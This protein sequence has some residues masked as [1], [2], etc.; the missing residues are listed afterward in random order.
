[1]LL[2]VVLLSLAACGPGGDEVD[3]YFPT[4]SGLRWTY[5]LTR[6][7]MDG[8]QVRP[9]YVEHRG[10]VLVAGRADSVLEQRTF[11]GNRYFF[12]RDPT[13]GWLRL[14]AQSATDEAPRW[15]VEPWLVLPASLDVG[16]SWQQ[17]TPV[18][19]LE[20]T[21]PPQETLFRVQV[22]LPVE[23]R[24]AARD[25][26]VEVPAGSF[27]GCLRIEGRGSISTHLGN[28]LGLG[29]VTVESTAWFAPGVG[30]VKQRLVE[31]TNRPALD[32]G[33]MQLE[34]TRLNRP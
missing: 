14:G 16:R 20:K 5:R 6:T 13:R 24:L 11:D 27:S 31:R 33:E 34:L 10:P 26:R 32:R 8:S 12:A 4:E 9:Y 17:L 2:S 23:Y 3:R 30:L 29:S 7:T 21:G 1:M 19:V 22:S 15:A 28:Y 25:E 18:R